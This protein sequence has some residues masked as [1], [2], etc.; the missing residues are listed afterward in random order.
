MGILPAA[1]AMGLDFI[2]VTRERYD[3]IIPSVYF[4]D[5]KIQRVM[6]TIRSKEFKESV[7]RMGGY[8]VSRTGEELT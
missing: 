2:P 3:L 4:G 7:L 6:E 5:Q 1:K 8:D